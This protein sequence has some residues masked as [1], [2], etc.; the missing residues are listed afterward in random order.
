[1]PIYIYIQTFKENGN[2][3]R[4]FEI[5]LAYDIFKINI[6]EYKAVCDNNNNIINFTFF[7]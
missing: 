5:S 3:E 1:M 2:Y 4:D 7:K 6:A